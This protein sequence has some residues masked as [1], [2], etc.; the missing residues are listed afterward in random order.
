MPALA[1]YPTCERPDSPRGCFLSGSHHGEDLEDSAAARVEPIRAVARHPRVVR[2]R[3]PW[4]EP[5]LRSAPF[6][7]LLTGAFQSPSKP[8]SAPPGAVETVS[9]PPGVFCRIPGSPP[10]IAQDSGHAP[11]GALSRSQDCRGS[12]EY[13]ASGNT[14]ECQWPIARGSTN[15]PLPLD[16]SLPPACS[17]SP[18]PSPSPS[19]AVSPP[20]PQPDLPEQPF[21]PQ[22]ANVHCLTVI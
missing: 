14:R 16:L 11:P 12:A 22:S 20:E 19:A 9:R 13:R 8:V 2:F 7:R 17:P 15:L 10:R 21:P 5:Q 4:P 18:S 1:S 3:H 6:P